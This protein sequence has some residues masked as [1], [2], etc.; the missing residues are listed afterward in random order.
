MVDGARAGAG[1]WCGCGSQMKMSR[2]LAT[3]I[4]CDARLPHGLLGRSLPPAV[5][6]VLELRL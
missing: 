6:S 3:E 1:R 2:T 5:V 4:C